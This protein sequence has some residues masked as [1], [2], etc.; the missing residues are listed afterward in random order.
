MRITLAELQCFMLWWNGKILKIKKVNISLSLLKYF[1]S[2]AGGE[3]FERVSKRNVFKENG[4]SAKA[5]VH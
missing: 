5:C 2:M 3:L 1:L 4:I